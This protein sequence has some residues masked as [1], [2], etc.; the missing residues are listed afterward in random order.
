MERRS[1]ALVVAGILLSALII[2]TLAFSRGP[3][4]SSLRSADL[5]PQKLNGGTIDTV[6]VIGAPGASLTLPPGVFPSFESGYVANVTNVSVRVEGDLF[7]LQVLVPPLGGAN[8]SFMLTSPDGTFRSFVRPVI[9][10]TGQLISGSVYYDHLSWY[11]S[12]FQHRVTGGISISRAAQALQGQLQALGYQAQITYYPWRTIAIPGPLPAPIIYIQDVIGIK[13]GS[14]T[15]DEWIVVGGHFDG[16]P[17]TTEA[18]YDNGAGTAAV[19]TLA[20]AMAHT[21]TNRTMVFAFWG[22]EEEGLHGSQKWLARDVP[23]GVTIKA[24]IN[25]DMPG[26]NWPAPFKLEEYIGPNL[27]DGAVED[28]RMMAIAQNVTLSF[29]RYPAEGFTIHEYHEDRSDAY[30]FIEQGI[31]SLGLIGEFTNYTEYHTRQD[32]LAFMEQFAGGK[33]MLVGGLNTVVWIS[34][35]ALLVLDDDPLTGPGDT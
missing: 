6:Q 27:D 23:P 31:P 13:Q 10:A 2:G 11:T 5:L 29:L 17:R 14:V 16:G 35:Y 24:N 21:T 19:L 20:E 22:G 1:K 4:E 33:D 12:T 3:L 32:T 18:A 7:S 25:L 9:N 28:P 34:L 26:I 30:Y 8:L 15:P